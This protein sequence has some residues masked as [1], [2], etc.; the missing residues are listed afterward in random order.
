MVDILIQ[1][2]IEKGLITQHSD[3]DLGLTEKGKF[4]AIEHKII[5]A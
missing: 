5:N 3:K 1:E 2:A 4:Y